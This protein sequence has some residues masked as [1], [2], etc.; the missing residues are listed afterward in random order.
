MK[1]HG[2]SS[3]GNIPSRSSS[4]SSSISITGLFKRG[5]YSFKV[6]S[7]RFIWDQ[8]KSEVHSL[9][10]TG[11][12][13]NMAGVA[14]QV[15][16]PPPRPQFSWAQLTEFTKC[17]VIGH[18]TSRYLNPSRVWQPQKSFGWFLAVVRANSSLG[19]S[20]NERSIF[21]L[22]IKGQRWVNLKFDWIYFPLNSMNKF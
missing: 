10:L 7:S 21:R 22:L 6:L 13:N 1:F 15:V 5:N 4:S 19:M 12:L 14:V 18:H 17:T 20:W 11:S 16:L 3:T 2:Y 8:L 9:Q